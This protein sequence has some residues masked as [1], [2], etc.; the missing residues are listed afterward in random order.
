MRPGRFDSMLVQHVNESICRGKE[1]GRHAAPEREDR[2]GNDVFQRHRPPD[3]LILAPLEEGITVNVESYPQYNMGIVDAGEDLHEPW[4]AGE[5]EFLYLEFNVQVEEVLEGK[6]LKAVTF[7]DV[8]DGLV[9][10]NRLGREG[11]QSL[12]YL[13]VGKTFSSL[14]SASGYQF[15]TQYISSQYTISSRKGKWASRRVKKFFLGISR[16]PSR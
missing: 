10:A 16:L 5:D 6:N 1:T 2:E 8:K 4:Y 15:H 13:V 7:C 14:G 3:S 9:S 12:V 11:S